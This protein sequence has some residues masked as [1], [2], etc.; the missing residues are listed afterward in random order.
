[1]GSKSR[2]G[3]GDEGTQT[4]NIHIKFL[5]TTYVCMTYAHT[6]HAYVYTYELHAS[7]YIRMYIRV[8]TV[9]CT[10][11]SL[12]EWGVG[13]SDCAGETGGCLTNT[14]NALTSLAGLERGSL[15]HWLL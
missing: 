9:V 14:P 13:Q 2:A 7:V 1:V 11:T 10:G 5:C 8:S 12:I 4:L 3:Q 6:L 15:L